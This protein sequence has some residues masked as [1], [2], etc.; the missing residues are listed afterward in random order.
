MKTLL[1]ALRNVFLSPTSL[2]LEMLPGIRMSFAFGILFY[3]LSVVG[4]N[5]LHSTSE[6][7]SKQGFEMRKNYI[8]RA[9]EKIDLT[10][11]QQAEQI[12]Q[13][14]EQS[15]FQ[16]T[17]GIGVGLLYTGF[18]LMVQILLFWFIGS[19]LFKETIYHQF[20]SIAIVF[21]LTNGVAGVGTMLTGTIQFVA[22]S[23]QIAPNAGIFIPMYGNEILFALFS[24]LSLHSLIEFIVAG[25][26]FAS[27]LNTER[28]KTIFLSLL[29]YFLIFGFFALTTYIGYK[30]M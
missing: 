23:L 24:R 27:V 3:T 7:L 14:H 29:T 1:L 16:L 9:G 6:P 10:K 15:Q 17:S 13:L 21:C 5:W 2:R 28:W 20:S 4:V 26:I 19:L 22:G 30:N 25:L 12:K 8:Q 18:G 11:E